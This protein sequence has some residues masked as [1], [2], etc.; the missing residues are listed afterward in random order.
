MLFSMLT[1]NLIE[2]HFSVKRSVDEDK[3]ETASIQEVTMPLTHCQLVSIFS[4]HSGSMLV[5]LLGHCL[6]KTTTN[7]G[8]GRD[9]PGHRLL[10]HCT[11]LEL[12][13][14]KNRFASG[15]NPFCSLRDRVSNTF[16]CF[17]ER[18]GFL[19]LLA[20]SEFIKM[21]NLL[22]VQSSCSQFNKPLECS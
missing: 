10:T 9:S 13:S 6:S 21:K 11:D 3:S 7:W 12:N 19:C 22:R 18:E 8:G 16:L 5:L 1:L 2:R 15:C 4:H 17:G 14:S 20:I